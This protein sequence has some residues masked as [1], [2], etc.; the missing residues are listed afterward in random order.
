MISQVQYDRIINEN[1]DNKNE[2]DTIMRTFVPSLPKK[3]REET[4]I[5]NTLARMQN[6]NPHVMWPEIDGIPINEFQ[7]IEYIV[8]AF[9]TLYPTGQIF[10]RNV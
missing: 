3:Q 10:V 7:T 4:A 6:E 2:D 5:N 1:D 8:R 9:P